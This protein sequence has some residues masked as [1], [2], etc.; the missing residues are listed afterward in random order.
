MSPVANGDGYRFL[1]A[2]LSDT[3]EYYVEADKLHSRHFVIN[4]KDFPAVKRV[5]VALRYPQGLGLQNVVLDPAGDVRAVNGTEADIS[6][7]TDRPLDAGVLVL[8]G[9]KKIEL[10]H[11][12]GNWYSAPLKIEKDGSYH[13]AALDGNEPVRI[14][15]DYFIE[16]KKDEAP[17][18][19]ILK[20]GHDPHVSPIEELPVTVS[21]SDDFGVQGLD[22]HYSVNGGDEKVV[23]LLKAKNSKEADGATTVYFENLKV[24][25]GDLVSFYATA[26][27]A[28]TTSQSEIIFAQAEPFDFQVL[29]IATVGRRRGWRNGQPVERHIAAAKADHRCHI[30][31]GEGQRQER[32]CTCGRMRSFCPTSNPNWANRLRPWPSAWEA[33]RWARP[34]P[35][36]NSSRS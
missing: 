25:P 31:R 18:V 21:A 6:V 4:V 8:D 19:K 17:S 34:D 5:R 15:D 22:L 3:V 36:L 14:S 11:V 7:L 2:G 12:E 33:V 24:V 35:S 26:R 1:F 16:A 29:P 23:P 28:K 20:P 9:G 13:V 32:R 27:D 10:K 30:Q